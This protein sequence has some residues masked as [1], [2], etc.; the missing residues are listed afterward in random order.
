MPRSPT[1]RNARG[2]TFVDGPGG[3]YANILP[4]ASG[5]YNNVAYQFSPGQIDGFRYLRFTSHGL[6][7]GN[8]D[9]GTTTFTFRDS[10]PISE[11]ERSFMRLQVTLAP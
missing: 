2:F 8:L 4:H 3:H 6:A 1:C 7:V 5:S 9:E 10:Q 11:E